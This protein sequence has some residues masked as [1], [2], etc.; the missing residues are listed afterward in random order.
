MKLNLMNLG[1]WGVKMNGIEIIS[2]AGI[3]GIGYF[4]GKIIEAIFTN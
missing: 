1:G 4:I 2:I 3:M